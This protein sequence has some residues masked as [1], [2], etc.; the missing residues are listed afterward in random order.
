MH[1]PLGPP[2]AGPAAFVPFRLTQSMLRNRH[3]PPYVQVHKQLK[4]TGYTPLHLAAHENCVEAIR[5]LIHAKGAV[6]NCTAA[7][8]RTALH[9]AAEQL[10]LGAIRA[11]LAGALRALRALCWL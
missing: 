9:L 3:P 11:L 10:H 5:M 8:K 6:P 4:D 2:K 1:C 7:Q